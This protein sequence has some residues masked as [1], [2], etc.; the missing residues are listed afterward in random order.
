MSLL[1]VWVA[2]PTANP[3]RARETLLKWTAMGYRHAV[4]L[5]RG[6]GTT[7]DG[8]GATGADVE[9]KHVPYCGFYAAGNYLSALLV[10]KHGADVVVCAN[11]DIDPDPNKEA[12]YIAS[13][14]QNHAKSGL[15]ICQPSGD[16]Q[17]WIADKKHPEGGTAA[18]DRICGSP[19][20]SAEYIRR[21]YNGTG[22]WPSYYHH[23]AGD[24]EASAVYERLGLLWRRRDL[25][26]FHRHWSWKHTKKEAYQEATQSHWKNDHLIYAKRQ[27]LNF[28]GSD[29]APA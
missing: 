21:G 22:P 3:E 13:E 5:N 10:E 1:N 14:C 11:D 27:L 6:D 2:F 24:V 23:F 16:R 19:W 4:L 8:M 25:T 7:G 29:L 28:P 12:W 17:G 26:H 9:V 20:F 15:W 18:A